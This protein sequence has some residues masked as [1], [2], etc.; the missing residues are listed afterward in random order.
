MPTKKTSGTTAKRKTT[1]PTA[2]KS[3]PTKRKAVASAEPVVEPAAA[4]T[5]N[6]QSGDR[7]HEVARTIGSTVGGIVKKT[8]R[9]LYR[10]P[11]SE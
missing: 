3:A 9:V 2:K 5:P 11:Y 8:K 1:R 4:P 7:L 10:E 6:A